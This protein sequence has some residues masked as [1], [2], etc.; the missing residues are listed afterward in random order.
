[1]EGRVD[2][3]VTAAPFLLFNDSST[4]YIGYG[5]LGKELSLPVGYLAL[6]IVTFAKIKKT[7]LVRFGYGVTLISHEAFD[8]FN[9]LFLRLM[10]EW[11][12]STFRSPI[13]V[14]FVIHFV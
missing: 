5:R 8:S 14:S 11:Q 13:E 1:M 7:C 12:P 6:S 4:T 2:A 10:V 9:P 3:T